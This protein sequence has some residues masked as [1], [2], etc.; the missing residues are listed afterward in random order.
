[1][2]ALNSRTRHQYQVVLVDSER[3]TFS[4]ASGNGS[5]AKLRQTYA[6]A[7]SDLRAWSLM[8]RDLPRLQLAIQHVDCTLIEASRQSIIEAQDGTNLGEP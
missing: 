1:M 5:T 2:S 7:Q 4:P 3:G 8:F 6:E